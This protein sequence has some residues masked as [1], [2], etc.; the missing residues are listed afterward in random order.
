MSNAESASSE[1]ATKPPETTPG[2]D[3]AES[4]NEDSATGLGPLR[5]VELAWAAGFIDG[6]GCIQYRVRQRTR[7][8][9]EYSLSLYVGQVDPRPLRRLQAL[10]GGSVGLKDPAKGESRRPIYYWRVVYATADAALRQLLPYLSVK[11]EQA[12][13][14][15]QLRARIAAYVRDG[16]RVS[17][18][19][20]AAR[21]AV[22]S[23]IKADKWRDHREEVMPDARLV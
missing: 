6:E 19:E 9:H 7:G 10:F 14:A 22:V 13:L 16:R 12:E 2:L 11:R 20:T 21:L 4:S 1:A 15:L 23:A 8:R 17:E 5:L 18:A 3:G